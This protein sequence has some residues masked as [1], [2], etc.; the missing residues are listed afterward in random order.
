MPTDKARYLAVWIVRSVTPLTGALIAGLC[1]VVPLFAAAIAQN[2]L[3]RP[4]S[5]SGLIFPFAL[6]SG[7]L[8][9]ALG[10]ALG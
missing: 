1:V 7:V 3:G 5:T 4:S 2:K 9:A 8:A 6:I 10:A